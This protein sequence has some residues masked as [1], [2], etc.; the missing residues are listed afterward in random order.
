MK[1][2]LIFFLG[3]IAGII[4]TIG[5]ILIIAKIES[6]KANSY[7]NIADNPI[8]FTLASKFKVFQVTDDGALA[9]CLDSENA[10][11]NELSVS[12]FMNPL[13][14]I[15]ADTQNQFYDGQIIEVP[16]GKKIMQIGTY[17]YSTQASEKVV[18]LIEFQ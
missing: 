11:D 15:L 8:P 6:N 13:V 9:F 4:L 18:P 5:S 17:R 12:Y 14:F 2:G 3:M 16:T 10:D 1:K 7:Y